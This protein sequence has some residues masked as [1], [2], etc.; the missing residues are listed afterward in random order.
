MS[1]HYIA[2]KFESLTDAHHQY[3]EA[4]ARTQKEGYGVSF[5]L[6]MVEPLNYPI[7]TVIGERVGA[8][9]EASRYLGGVPE[10]MPP[11][12]IHAMYLRRKQMTTDAEPNTTINEPHPPAYLNDDGTL[13]ERKC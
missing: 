8:V 7:I 10:K 1:L 5:Y 3:E 12:E 13:E 2:R 6:A 9:R 11:N 4:L